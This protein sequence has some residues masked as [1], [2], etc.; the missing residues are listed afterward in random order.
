MK[1]W[2]LFIFILII[3]VSAKAQI[4]GIS[5]GKLNAISH[6]PLEK[7]TAEFE[8]NYGFYSASK[9]W[10]NDGAL[11]LKY[12]SEDSLE[13]NSQVSFRMAYPFSDK[14]ELG[15][16]IAEDFTNWS[17]K[18][19][20]LN[21]AKFGMALLGGLNFP[22]GTTVIDKSQRQAEE[23]SQFILG[24]ASSHQ[25]NEATSVDLNIQYQDYFNAHPEIPNSD[26]FL[27][28]DIGHYIG[29]SGIQLVS[30]ISYQWSQFENLSSTK[31]TFYPGVS[32]EMDGNYGFVLNGVFDLLGQNAEKTT[33]I[34]FAWTLLID[35]RPKE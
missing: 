32:F 10:D 12:G 20:I 8:P 11:K 13:I 9:F 24:I 26:I 28:A 25:F 34:N 23:H 29:D 16:F 15:T 5:N 27:F 31:A 35:S 22:F 19:T 14:F 1:F 7:G 17:F 4:G 6:L 2:T 18:Y 33:G 30:S 3:N 21:Q